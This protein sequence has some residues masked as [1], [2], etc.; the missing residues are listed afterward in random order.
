MTMSKRQIRS[1]KLGSRFLEV[2]N[3]VSQL[4]SLNLSYTLT[5]L[6]KFVTLVGNV[7]NVTFFLRR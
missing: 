1:Q 3:E 4:F 5:F 2:E 7:K 6:V